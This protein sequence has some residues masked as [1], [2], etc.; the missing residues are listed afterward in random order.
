MKM[1][2]PLEILNADLDKLNME[3]IVMR[4]LIKRI[5]EMTKGP[6]GGNSQLES[7]EMIKQIEIIKK[8]SK[9][10]ETKVLD[11]LQKQLRQNYENQI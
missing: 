11:E 4:K 6:G 5:K 8:N 10:E 7:L 2:N 9:L 1:K 3:D